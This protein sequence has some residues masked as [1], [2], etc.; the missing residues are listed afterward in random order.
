MRKFLIFF[1]I[2]LCQT[3]AVHSQVSVSQELVY[4]G[5]N[6][7]QSGV[8]LNKEG[9]T[10]ILTKPELD[11]YKLGESQRVTGYVCTPVGVLAIFGGG[12]IM[13]TGF[14]VKADPSAHVLGE[15]AIMGPLAIG[16]GAV[17]VLGGIAS[18]SVGIV[19]LCRAHN[20][21]LRVAEYHNNPSKEITLS[22]SSNGIGL[23]LNF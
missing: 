1:I 12:I 20:T 22:P 11:I 7:Y 2:L 21:M 14:K 23:A 19:Y 17:L 18:T 8:K 15:N 10:N 13:N 4:K 5:G 6:F 16:V 9:L 3:I